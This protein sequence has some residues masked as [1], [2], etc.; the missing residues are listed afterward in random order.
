MRS[1][2]GDT[3]VKSKLSREVIHAAG[4][5]QTQGVSHRLRA[6]HTLARDWTETAVGQSCRHNAG[7]LTGHLNGAQLIE[8]QR[9]VNDWIT[10]T[11]KNPVP[12]VIPLHQDE[13]YSPGSRSPGW[14][15]CPSPL[16]NTVKDKNTLKWELITH[17][18]LFF[19]QKKGKP[20]DIKG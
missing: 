7:T 15:S 14:T 13:L 4:V 9:F 20:R 11:N 8:K 3:D 12:L 16:E 1:G 6:Q 19:K 10:M 5:H 2:R 17:L 18:L